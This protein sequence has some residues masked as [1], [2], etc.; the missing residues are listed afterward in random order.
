[1]K[2]DSKKGIKRSIF[3]VDRGFQFKY[4]IILSFLVVIVSGLLILNINYFINEV[5]E[6]FVANYKAGSIEIVSL[7]KKEIFFYLVFIS[8][9]LGFLTFFLG[10]ILSHKISGPV[11]V[12]KRKI[13]N[14]LDGEKNV[15]IHL[16]KGDEFHSLA[17]LVN[18]L[19]KKID[20]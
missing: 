9:T 15:E 14:V 19:F 16:R 11:M 13:Q 5:V 20:K 17:N 8:L 1:M 18:K 7:K 12:I 10:V 2:K 3:I 4:S 6:L